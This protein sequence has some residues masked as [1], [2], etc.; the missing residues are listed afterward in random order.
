M[1]FGKPWVVGFEP[2]LCSGIEKSPF[3]PVKLNQTFVIYI[4]IRLIELFKKLG[5]FSI[6]KALP[7]VKSLIR[8]PD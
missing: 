6:D 3:E 1:S 5:G 2:G 7:L 4:L 8:Q